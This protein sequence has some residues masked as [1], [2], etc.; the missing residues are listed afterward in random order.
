MNASR[1]HVQN[2]QTHWDWKYI[3]GCQGDKGVGVTAHGYEISW[4]DENVLKL[5]SHY[6]CIFL[7]IYTETIKLCTLKGRVWHVDYILR[8][9]L[10]LDHWHIYATVCKTESQ[11]EAAVRTQGAQPSA[12][13]QPRGEGWGAGSGEGWGGSRHMCTCGWFTTFYG[14]S[15]HNIVKQLFSNQKQLLQLEKMRL[16]FKSKILTGSDL[17]QGN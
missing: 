8:K 15:Q 5:H 13:W 6:G 9:L 11:W 14:R 7:L 4:G 1:W 3:N 17:V 2:R 12:L 10:F 16:F